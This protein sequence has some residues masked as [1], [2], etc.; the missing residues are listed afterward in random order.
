MLKHFYRE[1]RWSNA[2]AIVSGL[3]LVFVTNVTLAD[4]AASE[5]EDAIRTTIAH[6]DEALRS[7]NGS[8]MLYYS[9]EFTAHLPESARARFSKDRPPKPDLRRDISSITVREGTA[10]VCG[11]ISGIELGDIDPAT[12][13]AQTTN[14]FRQIMVT[15]AGT[16][17]L[18]RLIEAPPAGPCDSVWGFTVSAGPA[19]ETNARRCERPCCCH[20]SETDPRFTG[21]MTR[22]F[23]EDEA[24]CRQYAGTCVDKSECVVVDLECIDPCCCETTQAGGVTQRACTK[25]ADCL[26]H[27]GTCLE[28]A[29]CRHEGMPHSEG[30]TP[31]P[32]R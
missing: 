21:F 27:G 11:T 29:R 9:S 4:P 30:I 5:S 1:T 2:G 7:G 25:E 20:V 10:I 22:R 13:H 26:T 19:R 24:W 6:Y 16:W 15:E 31:S 23:C 32:P 8:L 17:K 12:G 18:S 28:R 14:R 3:C